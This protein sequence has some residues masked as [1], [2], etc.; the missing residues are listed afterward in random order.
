MMAGDAALQCA[1]GQ[2]FEIGPDTTGTSPDGGV[3]TWEWAN[4]ALADMRV[5]MLART[6]EMTGFLNDTG[7]SFVLR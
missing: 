4:S 6:S 5:S 7:F 2:G 3:T 1:W